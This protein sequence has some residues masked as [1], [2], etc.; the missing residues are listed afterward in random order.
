[1]KA[2]VRAF[3]LDP[4]R[5]VLLLYDLV[6]LMR[7]GQEVK[8]SKRK[9]A[10]VAIGDVVD[11]VG[12]DAIHFHLLSRSAESVV[13]FDLD[14]AVAQNNENPVFYVQYGHARICSILEKARGEGFAVDADPAA[15]GLTL[16]T[17]PSEFALIRKILELE[18]QVELA[19]DRLAP[20]LL[21]HYSIDLAKHFSAFYRDCRVV[22]PANR[23]LSDARLALC[24]AA[25]TALV[26]TLGLIGVSAPA[27]M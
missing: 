22:D 17:H 24:R 6:K 1:M 11:E 5:L 20:H 19:A 25:R 15:A 8:L 12:S 23:P 3:G 7:E 16:L 4:D 10:L 27:S 14:L 2:I 13:E 18:E 21:T 9:G 26:Q